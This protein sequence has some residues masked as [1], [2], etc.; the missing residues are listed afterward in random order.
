LTSPAVN[1][2]QT[3]APRAALALVESRLPADPFLLT[4]FENFYTEI[5]EHKSAIFAQTPGAPI[6]TQPEDVR[7]HLLALLLEQEERVSRTGTLLGVEM[8]RQ[9]QRV[10]ACMA[11]EVFSTAPWL[12]NNSWRSLE[13]EL[14]EAERQYGLA[15]DGP[16]MKK[17]DLLLQQDDPAYRELATVY[18][19]ALALAKNDQDDRQQY[20]RPLLDMIGAR[21][22]TSSDKGRVFAQSYAHTLSENKLTTLPSAR[23][24]WLALALIVA[25]WLSISWLAWN[26]LSPRIQDTLEEIHR[27]TQ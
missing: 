25:A 24:W 4:H 11:D 15:I 8:Y 16:C 3:T 27:L 6:S 1:R 22:G 10:M 17:L 13:V 19:Y 18:F 5:V 9:A 12:T 26:Q 20:W 7:E 21:N 2:K 23:R 14:F